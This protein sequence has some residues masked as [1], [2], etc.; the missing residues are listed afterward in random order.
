MFYRIRP[1]KIY[2]LS[3]ALLFSTNSLIAADRYSVSSGN[4]NATSTWS[5]NSGGAPGASVPGAGD[6]VYIENGHTI[7]IIANAEC[8]AI[9]F[10]GIS[11]NLTVN[12]TIT[13]TVS[14]SITLNKQTNVSSACT[15]TG[16]GTIS[17]SDIHVGSTLNAPAGNNNVYSYTFSSSIAVF[18]ISN[19]LTVNSY[20]TGGSIK[21]AG[22]GI[23]NLESG[24][25]NVTGSVTTIAENNKN[26]VTF[27]MAAGASTGTL[28]L[29]GA[30]PF[31]VATQESIINLNGTSTLVKYTRAGAQTMYNTDYRNITLSGSGAKNIGNPGN[32]TVNGIISME[33]TA[34]LTGKSPT[35]GTNAILQYKGSAAQTTGLEFPATFSGSGGVIIDNSNGVTLNSNRTIN[36]LLILT[37]GK[38][39][40]ATNTLSL[41]SGASVTGAGTGKYIY[42]NLQKGIAVNTTS[43]TFE[44]GDASI[45]APVVLEFTGATNGTGSITAKTTAGDHANINTSTIN[46]TYSVNRYWTLTNIGVTGF[47]SYAATFTFVT[48][49]MDP[50]SD[51]NSFI[52]GNY[53]LTVW[54]YPSIGT[55]TATSTQAT[56]LTTFGDFQIGNPLA[57]FRSA[58]SGN[59]NQPATWE[60]FIGASW[61]PATTTPSSAD[62]TINI[63]SPHSVTNTTVVTVD[64][65]TIDAGGTLILSSNMIIADGPGT[66]IS[67]NGTLD[68]GAATLSGPGSFILASSASLIIG[69]PEGITSSGSTG[70]IQTTAR[71]FSSGA[72]Y[73]YSGTSAQVTG[74]G[75]PATLNN[76]TINNITGVTLS[77]PETINGTVTLTSGALAI[78]TNTLTF[79]NSDIPIIR[80]SGTITT[81]S[82]SNLSFGSPGNTG[83]SSFIIPAGTF[84]TSPLINNFTINRTNSLTLNEQILSIA[85]IVLC[86]GPL[87]TNDNLTLVSTAAGTALIDGSSTGQITGNVTIQRYLSS[88]FGYKYFSS[89]FQAATVNEFADDMILGPFTFYRYDESR[90]SSGWVSYNSPVTNPLIVLQGYAVNFG[91]GSAPNTVDVTGVVNRGSLSVTLY[92]HN[93]IYTKGFNLVGNPYPSPVDWNAAAGWT[94]TNIDNALY[95]FKAS[96]TDQYGG[97]YSTYING[98]SSDGLATNIIP[99]MQGFFVHVSDGTYPVTGTLALNDSVRI[100][101]QTHSFLKSTSVSSVPLLRL[102]ATF[103]DDSTSGDPAVL[104]FDD[105]ASDSFDGMMDAL[106]LYNTDLKV[107]NLYSTGID[108]SKL[109]INALPA[110]SDNFCKVPL[111]LKINKTGTIIFRIHD[112]DETLSTMRIY[113]TD[114]VAGTEQDL[115]PDEKYTVYLSSGEYLNRFYINLS[116]LTTDI[117]NNS[118]R[119]DLFTVYSD[120]GIIKTEI[121]GESGMRG[122]FFIYSLTGQ[123]LYVKKVYEPGIHEFNPG[124]KN[125]FYII[126]FISSSNRS[127]KKI[128]INN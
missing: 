16:S 100:N 34:T 15:V 28:N 37:S 116:N 78:G 65:L 41:A 94:K 49:D 12:N 75:L 122:T 25:V 117:K 80:T 103:S 73:T 36:S 6:N 57:N 86:N 74:N 35:Y 98:V 19:N 14:G 10:T 5:S 96:A 101:D 53:N 76:L 47:T 45:Y 124:L 107:P 59:W 27:S 40:T 106:K 99:S 83:G 24:V 9:T 126:T 54:S 30:S 123:I 87:I 1:C 82:S 114:I 48:G 89:P 23:Y 102:T 115:L 120:H 119:N 64:E 38:I 55:R 110:I 67:V 112:I 109:S 72:N 18:N 56:S 33:G 13:L 127:S 90:T 71:T 58:A 70:N 42:G 121:N 3:A 113:I 61:L 69:S 91:S 62:G 60:A 128:F 44:I 4:W 63:R 11:A 84:T 31:N 108:G 118:R 21:A 39:T 97:T 8:S 88:G 52:I 32:V 20:Y 79:Q 46:P 2:Y 22:N 68:C 85:G 93:N 77:G 43:K 105:K 125:G 50:G 51:S 66:D 92:N 95:Y 104:Y 26:V 111:G 81:S 7:T 29:S 17:C